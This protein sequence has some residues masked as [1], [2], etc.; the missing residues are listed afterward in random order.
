MNKVT[1]PVKAESLSTIKSFGGLK[2]IWLYEWNLWLQLVPIQFLKGI[3]HTKFMISHAATKK[4][5]KPANLSDINFISSGKLS[6]A[7]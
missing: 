6:I 2:G 3:A 5:L 7:E 1:S 4:Y